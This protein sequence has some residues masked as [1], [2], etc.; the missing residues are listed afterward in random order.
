[1]NKPIFKALTP[2]DV[3]EIYPALGCIGTLANMR[4]KKTGPRFFKLNRKVVYK[5][6]DIEDFLFQN[7]VQTI[8]STRAEQ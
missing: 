1:M 7:P 8:D 6:E 5:P 2:K 3:I 4:C